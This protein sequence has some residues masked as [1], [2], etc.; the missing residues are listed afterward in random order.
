MKVR[1]RALPLRS[2][3]RREVV[4]GSDGEFLIRV[5]IRESGWNSDNGTRNVIFFRVEFQLCEIGIS[6]RVVGIRGIPFASGKGDGFAVDGHVGS[7]KARRRIVNDVV[8][9]RISG[10]YRL[11]RDRSGDRTRVRLNRGV[12]RLARVSRERKEPDGG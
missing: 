9:G 12:F 6:S 11:R 10:Q 4:H 7:G 8:S 3:D 2:C 5:V 1:Y